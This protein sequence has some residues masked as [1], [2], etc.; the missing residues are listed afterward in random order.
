MRQLDLSSRRH[1]LEGMV[2]DRE[3]VI[4]LSEEFEADGDR[5]WSLPASMDCAAGRHAPLDATRLFGGP[6]YQ[7]RVR[8]LMNG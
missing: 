3:G 7:R 6:A 8:V 4:R 2:T 5:L 1:L